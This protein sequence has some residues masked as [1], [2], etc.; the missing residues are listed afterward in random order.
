MG[1]LSIENAGVGRG[2][3]EQGQNAS[4]IKQR[5]LALMGDLEGSRSHWDGASGVA[6]VNAKNRLLEQF[7][8]I[9]AST[10]RIAEG[11]GHTQVHT[12]TADDTSHGD[13]SSSGAAVS[14]LNSIT[15]INV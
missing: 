11:L 10:G 4:A 15:N 2:G 1:L 8:G 7:D 3:Q 5:M 9:F 14:G 6:F 13:M 12:N